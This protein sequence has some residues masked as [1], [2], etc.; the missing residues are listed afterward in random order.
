MALVDMLKG[1]ISMG[2]PSKKD[3]LKS[4][5]PLKHFLRPLL[6]EDIRRK[7]MLMQLQ[8]GGQTHMPGG[9]VS[10]VEPPSISPLQNALMSN[11]QGSTGG[12]PNEF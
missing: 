10:A 9:N 5:T 3:R 12:M 4:E 2:I 6:E 8:M 1:D 11:P 7:Q